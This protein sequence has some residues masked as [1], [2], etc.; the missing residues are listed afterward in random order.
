LIVIGAAEKHG[1]AVGRRA[2]ATRIAA[3]H[4]RSMTSSLRCLS[5]AQ[6]SYVT[7][8]FE[9]ATVADAM[10]VGI[11]TCPP[12]ASLAIV[13]RTMANHTMAADR[14]CMS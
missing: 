14:R 8:G 6:G 4:A 10:H 2:D 9:R 3:G 7:P 1:A 11:V 5:R 13:A 12:R